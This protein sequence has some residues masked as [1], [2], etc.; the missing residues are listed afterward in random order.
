MSS[1]NFMVSIV[2]HEK[3]VL[4]SGLGAWILV[5]HLAVVHTCTV[6]LPLHVLTYSTF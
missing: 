4:T 3:S 5:L 6:V 2:G 1:L